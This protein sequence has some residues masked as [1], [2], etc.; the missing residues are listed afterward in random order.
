VLAALHERQVTGR[1]RWIKSGLFEN[2]MYLVGPHMMQHAVTGQP[3]APMPNRLASW[4]VYD[5]FD[6]ADGQVFIGVVT[7][8]QWAA[9]C[10]AFALPELKADPAL[11]SN[12][13]RVLQRDRFMPRLRDLLAPM[14]RADVLAICERIGLPFA[15]INRPEDMFDD[16]HLAH[17]GAMAEITIPGGG[18]ARIPA[19]PLEIDG[20]RP[21]VRRDVPLAGADTAEICRELGLSDAAIAEL[22][23]EGSITGPDA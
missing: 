22:L 6:V 14:A 15:P 20:A 17:P 11:G 13:A 7:D 1:G 5:I 4:A 8:T 2:C 23:G 10:D 19:L 16:P 12:R 21:A 9:F 3:A 18:K